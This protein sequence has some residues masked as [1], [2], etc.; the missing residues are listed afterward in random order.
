MD[1][2]LK[3]GNKYTV[4]SF[5]GAYVIEEYKPVFDGLFYTD[6]GRRIYCDNMREVREELKLRNWGVEI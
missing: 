3:D 6:T 2:Y 5:K 4:K 1:Y